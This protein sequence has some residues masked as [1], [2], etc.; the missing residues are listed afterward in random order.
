MPPVATGLIPASLQHESSF[1]QEN[2]LAAQQPQSHFPFHR[3]LPLG[4][5]LQ[6]KSKAGSLCEHLRAASK[7]PMNLGERNPWIWSNT[8]P[9]G[10]LTSK[11]TEAQDTG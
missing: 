2:P 8:S 3:A 4:A 9:Y 10:A 1:C 5:V 7:F 6:V 11:E